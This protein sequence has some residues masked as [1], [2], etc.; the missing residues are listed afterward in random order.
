MSSKHSSQATLTYGSK[1]ERCNENTKK[2]GGKSTNRDLPSDNQRSAVP[3]S[4]PVH[5]E[6]AQVQEPNAGATR[7]ALFHPDFLDSTQLAD[8]P[9]ESKYKYLCTRWE[10]DLLEV[11]DKVVK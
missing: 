3:E 7:E 8:I 4:K 2:S 5:P 9:A 6:H 10:T 1:R 11:Y